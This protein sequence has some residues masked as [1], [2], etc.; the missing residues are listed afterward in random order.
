MLSPFPY[1]P[2]LPTTIKELNYVNTINYL[3]VS[4]TSLERITHELNKR[5]KH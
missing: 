5:D 2:K 3:L 1:C 4:I